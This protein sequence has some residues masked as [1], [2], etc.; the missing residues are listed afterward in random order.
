MLDL[1][2]DINNRPVE[3]L[4]VPKP[5]QSRPKINLELNL[6]VI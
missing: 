4:D 2:S 3:I 1:N 5:R 6:T